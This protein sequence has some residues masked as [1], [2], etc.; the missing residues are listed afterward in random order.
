MMLMKKERSMSVV[1]LMIKEE[2]HYLWRLVDLKCL[3]AII[4]E[5]PLV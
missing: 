4:I 3:S 2:I 1:N 5:K